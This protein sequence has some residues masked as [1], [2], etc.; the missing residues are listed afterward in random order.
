MI[1]VYI[2][3]KALLITFLLWIAFVC[4]SISHGEVNGQTSTPSFNLSLQ[5]QIYTIDLKTEILYSSNYYFRMWTMDPEVHSFEV[6]ILKPDYDQA[7]RMIS[8][9]ESGN[10]QVYEQITTDP[11]KV[12]VP[13]RWYL[14]PKRPLILG[15]PFDHYELSFLIAINMSTRLNIN[16]TWFIMHPYMQGEWSWIESPTVKKLS[17]PPNN[18]SLISLGLSPEKFFQYHCDG[19]TDF[20]LITESLGF[21]TM[22]SW[23]ITLAY[24]LP[25][26]TILGVLIISLKKFKKLSISDFLTLYLGV[27][28]FILSF[29][30]SFYQFAPSKVITV[31]EMIFY[32][33]FIF[34]TALVI[35]ALSRK[36]VSSKENKEGQEFTPK[37]GREISSGTAVEEAFPPIDKAFEWFILL[38]TVL[39][40]IIFQFLTWITGPHEALRLVA[41]FMF[42]L[43]A[44][45]MLSIIAWLW[46]FI[47]L[48]IER[49]IFLRLFAWSILSII[50]ICY[51]QLFMVLVI[52]GLVKEAW[53]IATI[54]VLIVSLST[55]LFPYKQIVNSYK[56]TTANSVF[57]ERGVIYVLRPYIAGAFAAALLIVL[58]LIIP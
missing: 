54:A 19:M 52:F 51:V 20:Y 40:G 6:V 45:L 15:T 41:K 25:S 16:D 10:I 28:L 12:S 24:L 47:T 14:N 18:Q 58:P 43:L 29:L 3:K 34:A 32:I 56:A 22:Y 57:W 17:G 53:T 11:S 42:S 30:V 7:I 44:P 27:G 5:L 31:Q 9:N 2:L 26:V 50:F 49:R 8:W 37:A 4:G 46:Q 1:E 21:P 13:W 38:L 48:N 36:K 33:D 55:T 35:A 39:V 23:R